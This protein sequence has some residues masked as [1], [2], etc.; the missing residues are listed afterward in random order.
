MPG[1]AAF[2]GGG[3]GG[4]GIKLF[5][6]VPRP[7]LSSRPSEEN[8]GEVVS[9]PPL[10]PSFRPRMLQG[11]GETSFFGALQQEERAK[12]AVVLRTLLREGR[13]EE[14]FTKRTKKEIHISGRKG[15]VI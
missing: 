5:L 3:G 11:G 13:R 4:G 1:E 6:L 14:E 8:R 10:S 12:A 2:G 9:I 7:S 15:K